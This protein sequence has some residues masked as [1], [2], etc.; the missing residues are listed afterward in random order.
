MDPTIWLLASF[1]VFVAFIFLKLRRLIATL[2]IKYKHNVLDSIKKAEDLKSKS[3]TD[4]EAVKAQ[5][6]SFK[7]TEEKI[8]A[9]TLL[10]IEKLDSETKKMISEYIVFKER[11]VASKVEIFK[12]EEVRKLKGEIFD[13]SFMAITSYYKNGNKNQQIDLSTLTSIKPNVYN[14]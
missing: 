14:A 1:L 5:Y 3:K 9:T 2:F 8:K 4:L 10:E 7:E 12:L 13:L 6:Q 11:S